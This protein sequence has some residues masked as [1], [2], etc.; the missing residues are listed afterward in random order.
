MNE[1]SFRIEGIAVAHKFASPPGWF[2][3]EYSLTRPLDGLVYVLS[4]S[5]SYEYHDGR[6]FVARTD[7]LLYMPAGTPYLTRCGD[8]EFLHMTVNFSR[9]G[10]L[11]LPQC[12]CC[13][14]S[15]GAK[16]DMQKLIEEWSRR[17]PN[18]AERCTGMLYLLICRELDISRETAHGLNE[19]LQNA[20]RTIS[21]TYRQ[22]ISIPELAQSCGMSETYFRRLFAR[23]Y[24]M[25]PGDYITHLRI[26]YA[27][28]LLK[29]T[30]LSVETI[31]YEC[32]YGDPAYFCRVFKKN[33]G[34]PPSVYRLN[35]ND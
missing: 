4:G 24:G 34:L 6:S 16:R 18:Y 35:I 3:S 17:Q 32:G 7:D 26:S 14:G 15:P 25:S 22:N 9:S 11:P 8:E 13:A 29:N 20:V 2:S 33:N 27:C 12:R 21:D 30:S 5:A 23:A 28:E 19:K 31:G 1:P 10:T